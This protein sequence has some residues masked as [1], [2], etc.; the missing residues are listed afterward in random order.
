[1]SRQLPFACHVPKVQ[2][3]LYFV[4]CYSSLDYPTP[5]EKGNKLP[6]AGQC[7][8]LAPGA[9]KF[10]SDNDAFAYLGP[11]IYIL[12]HLRTRNGFTTSLRRMASS[13]Y[14][15]HTAPD[16][17]LHPRTR[18]H[19]PRRCSRLT[20]ARVSTRQT[21]VLG[22]PSRL[23]SPLSQRCMTSHCCLRALPP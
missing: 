11:M 6:E 17:R 21:T 8:L 4:P 19:P 14:L 5:R 16:P 22:S 23:P 12:H 15:S 1:M 13:P 9:V 18:L 20:L 3:N 7:M 2:Y 10:L